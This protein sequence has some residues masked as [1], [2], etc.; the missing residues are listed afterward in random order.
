MPV[1]CHRPEG[2]VILLRFAELTDARG[3]IDQANLRSARATDIYILKGDP[4]GEVFEPHFTYHGF[5][6]VEVTG[7]PGAPT[8]DHLQGIVIHSDLD[9][10]GTLRIDNSLIRTLWHNALWSQRSN[11]MGIPTDCPQRDERLGW[12]GDANVFWDA[13][14]FNMDVSAFTRRFM[15]DVRAAQ[16]VGG[17]FSDFSPAAFRFPVKGDRSGAARPMARSAMIVRPAIS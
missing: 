13:A 4:K 9:F 2:T 16:A 14:T 8:Q 6:Y 3:E 17:A 1:E 10:T 11:F 12:L 15:G 5:R 7:F